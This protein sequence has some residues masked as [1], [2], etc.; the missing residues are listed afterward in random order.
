MMFFWGDNEILNLKDSEGLQL[1]RSY[2]EEMQAC[3][4]K[5]LNLSLSLSLSLCLC[6]KR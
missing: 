1:G 5:I 6:V 4:A 2:P 3:P